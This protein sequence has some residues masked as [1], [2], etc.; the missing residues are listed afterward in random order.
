M[1]RLTNGPSDYRT[2]PQSG[3]QN[4]QI[5][6]Q[7]TQ[8][9]KEKRQKVKQRSIKHYKENWIEQHKP[10]LKPAPRKGKQFLLH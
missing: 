7:K 1:G 2:L 8:S 9:S 5:E 4:T 3:S 6:G 10:T